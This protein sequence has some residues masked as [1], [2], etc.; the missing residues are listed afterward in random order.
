MIQLVFEIDETCEHCKP[1]FK[2][3]R[4]VFSEKKQGRCGTHA[5]NGEYYVLVSLS[6]DYNPDGRVAHWHIESVKETH[7]K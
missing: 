1:R 4:R 3:V 7:K 2:E 6:A 5:E